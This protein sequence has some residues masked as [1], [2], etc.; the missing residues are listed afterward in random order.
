MPLPPLLSERP[1]SQQKL[2]PVAGAVIGGALTG[3]ALGISEA[4]WAILNIIM[5][6]GG[7]AAGFDHL[8]AAAGAR[9]GLFGG[10]VFGLALLAVH[11][12]GGMDAEATLPDPAILLAVVTTV[13]G[14]ALGALGGALRARAQAR[15]ALASE[16]AA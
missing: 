16:S 8:G 4:V 6:L 7:V 1:P 11:E 10:V 12:L 14:T 5:I 3:V 9:R 13:A 15:A 2:I